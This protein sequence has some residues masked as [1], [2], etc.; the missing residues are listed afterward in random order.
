MRGIVRPRTK[1]LEVK[2]NNSF[3][4]QKNVGDDGIRLE[5]T[6]L[7]SP[8]QCKRCNLS[9]PPTLKVVEAR[10][11]NRIVNANKGRSGYLLA[12]ICCNL[13]FFGIRSPQQYEAF[14]YMQGATT[15]LFWWI[16]HPFLLPQQINGPAMTSNYHH[17]QRKHPLA[18]EN[19]ADSVPV[20][21]KN[22]VM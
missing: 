7:R 22:V 11:P 9:I 3:S 6:V 15:N 13:H 2:V 5:T 18:L 17:H 1:E 12:R 10:I 20:R 16:Q 14:P 21:A 4:A 19:G 8:I